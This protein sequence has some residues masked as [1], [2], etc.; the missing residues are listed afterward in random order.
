MC[1]L[2]KLYWYF[3][4]FPKAPPNIQTLSRNRVAWGGHSVQPAAALG[5][6]GQWLEEAVSCF[7]GA[8]CHLTIGGKKK[9]QD[10]SIA[11]LFST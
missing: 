8:Q 4:L 6:L 5:S 7:A 10:P 9:L 11:K 2:F 1:C 3:L